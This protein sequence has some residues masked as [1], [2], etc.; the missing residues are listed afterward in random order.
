M[1]KVRDMTDEELNEVFNREYKETW[2][3]RN[4]SRKKL[5]WVTIIVMVP[6]LLLIICGFILPMII[7][8]LGIA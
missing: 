8:M 5:A 7:L 6:V 2:L 4:R 3:K 1:K